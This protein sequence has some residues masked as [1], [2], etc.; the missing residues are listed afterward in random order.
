MY[1]M[2]FK[3][4]LQLHG[5]KGSSTTNVSSY[6]PTD[7]EVR[8]QQQ[9]ADYSEAVAPNALWLNDTAK[10][11]LA[12]SIGSTQVDFNQLNNTAQSQIANAQS[13]VSGLLSGE[14][15]SAYQTNM[16]NSIKSGVNNS[17]GSLLSDLGS[18][19]V[20]NSSVMNKGVSD[21]NDAASEAMSNAYTSNIG[22]LSQ[23][24]GQQ[25]SGA[26]AGITAGAAAQEAAQQPALNLWNASLG[27]NGANTGALSAVAGQGT[28]TATQTTSGGSGLLGGLLSGYA[29][30]SGGLFCFA[31]GTKIATPNGDENIEDIVAGDNVICPSANGTESIEKVT[32]VLESQ[33]R[34]TYDIIGEDS[35]DKSHTLSTTSS[36]PLMQENGECI[37]VD[38]IEAGNTKL[39][40]RD[41]KVFSVKAVIHIFE[42]P[43]YDLKV[44]GDNNYYADGFI[45]KGGTNEW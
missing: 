28:T 22:L 9:A 20:I 27:L 16:E 36:Q 5:G 31:K 24:Y 1:Q 37:L 45:A 11:L 7:Q 42:R 4:I 25:S 6:T 12:D 29:S 3:L 26:T 17:M 44:T 8:L 40:M 13:G 35:E 34:E 21:I 30:N 32:E 10:G 43:V 41:G 18:K 2:Y 38:K 15:P 14:L 39:K 19:G 23:L 33:G